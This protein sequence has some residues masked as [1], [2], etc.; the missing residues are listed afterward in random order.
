MKTR[1]MRAVLIAVALATSSVLIAPPAAAQL[2]VIDPSNLAQNIQQAARALQQITN[3][4]RSLQNEAVMLQN[5]ARNL[6]NLNFSEVS[7][8]AADLQEIT[9]LMNRAQALRFEVQAVETLFQ[10]HYPQQYG[11]AM[12][13]A[14][15]ASD[16]ATRWRTAREAFQHTMMVQS[17]I[18]KTVQSDTIKLAGLVNASQG[19]VGALQ[20]NQATNQLLGLLIKQQLQLQ[21]LLAAQGRADALSEAGD[22]QSKES[23]RAAFTRFIGSGNAYTP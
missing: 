14:E 20:A 15:I 6:T 7:A 10:Q 18:A 3:Q 4:I 11:A 5:M 8:I 23:A 12:T 2:A 9:T 1:P 22:A 21:T 13:I 16:A 17:E 19:A